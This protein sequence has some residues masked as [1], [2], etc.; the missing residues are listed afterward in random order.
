MLS[1]NSIPYVVVISL[2][3]KINHVRCAVIWLWNPLTGQI[4]SVKKPLLFSNLIHRLKMNCGEDRLPYQNVFFCGCWGATPWGRTFLREGL[5]CGC[6]LLPNI[7][8]NFAI[9]RG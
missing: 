6:V 2:Q 1:V 4:V 5:A 8:H 3:G 9:V 7:I